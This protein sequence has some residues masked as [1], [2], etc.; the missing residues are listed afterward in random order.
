MSE[1]KGVDAAQ[2]WQDLREL[3]LER[4]DGRREVCRALDLSFIK[5]KALRRLARE[6]MSLSMLAGALQTDAPY[7]SVIVTDL[8]R[9]G[10][11]ARGPHPDD[12]RSK[13]VSVTPAGKRAARTAEAILGRP[14]AVLRALGQHDLAVLGR[15]VAATLRGV[16]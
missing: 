1:E 13:L 10:L 9:R 7:T 5:V 16:E 12:R 11:V 3:V 4:N 8:E 2:V 6:P 14:P 15:I